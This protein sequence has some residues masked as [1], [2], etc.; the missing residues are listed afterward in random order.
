MK[1]G[2]RHRNDILAMKHNIMSV[3]NPLNLQPLAR[4]ME[5]YNLHHST[6]PATAFPIIDYIENEHE[7]YIILS[8]YL[9]LLAFH[10]VLTFSSSNSDYRLFDSHHAQVSYVS[11]DAESQN[12]ILRLNAPRK[13]AKDVLHL[14][15]C[16]ELRPRT[17][18]L[19]CY[20]VDVC[21]KQYAMYTLF[22]I[23]CLH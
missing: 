5:R 1:E 10:H 20:W 22:H 15:E 8:V 2:G 16:S 19:L 3:N 7:R 23:D 12:E 6:P 18:R 17:H 4:I 21:G 9:Q 11:K 13:H 14:I